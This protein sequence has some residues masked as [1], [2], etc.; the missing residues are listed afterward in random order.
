[1]NLNNSVTLIVLIVVA[2]G[3]AVH[4][5][6]MLYSY[7]NLKKFEALKYKSNLELLKFLNELSV[8]CVLLGYTV[9]TIFNIKG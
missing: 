1:M 9:Y 4:L 7:H 2:V 3:F 8:G 6:L 5:G